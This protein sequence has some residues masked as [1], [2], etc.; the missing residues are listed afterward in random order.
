MKRNILVLIPLLLLICTHSLLAQDRIKQV[1]SHHFKTT[2]ESAIYECDILG[3]RKGDSLVHIAPAYSNFS[4]VGKT[5]NGEW[6][7]VRFWRWKY[8]SSDQL[9]DS[10]TNKQLSN[11][12]MRYWL[13]K[14]EDFNA[15]TIPRYST[16]ASFSSGTIVVP[17]KARFNQFDFST[18]THLGPSFGMRIRLSPYTSTNFF[19]VLTTFGISSIEL[20]SLNTRGVVNSQSEAAA[21]S[22][23][24]GGY[25]SFL[26]LRQVFSSVAILFQEITISIG[27]IRE[28]HGYQLVWVTL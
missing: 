8:G 1:P 25:S 18:D 19:N 9:I 11:G 5:L 15:K 23:A 6:V 16:D 17:V 14:K 26:M 22:F 21:L 3:N 4:K 27:F 12:K 28:S 7:V 2:V 13:M 10:M 24:L 20:D